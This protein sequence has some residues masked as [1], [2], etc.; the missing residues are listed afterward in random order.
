M[1][2]TERAKASLKLLAFLV[3]ITVAFFLAQKAQSSSLLRSIV[4]SYGYVGIFAISVVSGFNLAVPIPA[5]SFLPL[6]LASGLSLWGSVTV[7]AIGTALADAI[8]YLIGSAG[9]SAAKAKQS[10]IGERIL[11][12][13]DSHPVFPLLLLFVFAAFVPF[14]NEVVIIPLGFAGYRLRYILPISIMGN[15]IFNAL[16]A[17]GTLDIIKLIH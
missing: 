4:A 12:L 14:P 5:I 1:D 2:P 10:K 15:F 8:S 13:R 17:L 16:I 11:R 9:K 3:L 6:F 7:I